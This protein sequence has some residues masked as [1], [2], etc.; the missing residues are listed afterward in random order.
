MDL[1]ERL[2]AL[3][4]QNEESLAPATWEMSEEQLKD[5]YLELIADGVVP[6][7][8]ARKLKKTAT[9]F[10]RRRSPESAHYDEDFALRYDL[11][12][13]AGGEYEEALAQRA[14]AALFRA[15]EEGNVRAAEKILMAYHPNYSFL[16]PPGFSGDVT[17]DKFIQIM[18]GIPTELLQQ[19]REA[20]A[21]QK[22]LPDI[23]AA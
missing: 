9:W 13:R 4:E 1:R 3:H 23:E 21:R 15:A 12:R 16:R 7:M 14:E 8:A 19:M 11:I 18:P 5:A 22:E 6:D 2:Q 17:I 20:L 10:R